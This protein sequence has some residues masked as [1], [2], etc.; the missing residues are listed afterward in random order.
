MIRFVSQFLSVRV[1][2][3]NSVSD[4]FGAR[5]TRKTLSSD[6]DDTFDDLAGVVDETL[7]DWKEKI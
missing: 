3:R 7:A 6:P 5:E 4:L 1:L 2:K